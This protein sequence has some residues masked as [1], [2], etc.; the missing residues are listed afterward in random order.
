MYGTSEVGV[1]RLTGG[2]RLRMTVHES[3]FG[4]KSAS[5]KGQSI[6]GFLDRWL[7]EREFVFWSD[8]MGA[9]RYLC[10][11]LIDAQA[12]GYIDESSPTL[13]CEDNKTWS[14]SCIIELYS[15]SPTELAFKPV[16]QYPVI[17]PPGGPTA[18]RLYTEGQCV[19][20]E[21]WN[22]KKTKP[23]D[24]MPFPGFA[25]TDSVYRMSPAVRDSFDTYEKYIR[26]IQQKILDSMEVPVEL[27][28][29]NYDQMESRAAA[30]HGGGMADLN[31]MVH[32]ILQDGPRK[33]R[34]MEMKK[35]QRTAQFAEIL[36]K[37]L[38][39][40]RAEL[41]AAAA[42]IIPPDMEVPKITAMPQGELVEMLVGYELNPH[43]A[44]DE[45]VKGLVGRDPVALKNFL[46]SQH[47]DLIRY[48]WNNRGGHGV[49]HLRV[50][51]QVIGAVQSLRWGVLPHANTMSVKDMFSP[52]TPDSSPSLSAIMYRLGF[53]SR[54][55]RL[56]RGRIPRAYVLAETVIN[57]AKP[58]EV[59]LPN[60]DEFKKFLGNWWFDGMDDHQCFTSLS[61]SPSGSACQRCEFKELCQQC[62]ALRRDYVNDALNAVATPR[63]C[64]QCEY[65]VPIRPSGSK[66]RP[67]VAGMVACSVDRSLGPRKLM[68]TCDIK[69]VF[70]NGIP[71]TPQGEVLRKFSC[72]ECRCESDIFY[73]HT[74]TTGV[75][76]H[77]RNGRIEV[78]RHADVTQ[79]VYPPS[80]VACVKFVCASCSHTWTPEPGIPI[81]FLGE[82][83][84]DCACDTSHPEAVAYCSEDEEDDI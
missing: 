44:G 64:G 82:D 76:V 41:D 72:P 35:K 74:L 78:N 67:P 39:K 20:E 26:Y 7:R 58:S 75:P 36:G 59:G 65:R 55:V 11:A 56:L 62:S 1:V 27:L 25:V 3:A 43:E 12:K 60:P 81:K 84:V 57:G 77:L 18:R 19:G 30:L 28:G 79:R 23:S 5:E 40:T 68:D 49:K 52:L 63:T 2:Q 29:V 33:G 53:K 17:D 46:N 83:D 32:S 14:V 34:D 50:M 31:D 48:M 70:G 9:T 61:Y 16:G 13:R 22:P 47:R 71:L 10:D 24:F 80:S 4:R 15:S 54:L 42:L 8:V 45:I 37:W 21:P 38:G 66:W 51:K 69:D 73:E 6:H